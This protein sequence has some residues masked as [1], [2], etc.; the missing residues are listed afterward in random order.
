MIIEGFNKLGKY[1]R[2]CFRKNIIKHSNKNEE[3]IE[4]ISITLIQDGEE[5]NV[6]SPWWF[7]DK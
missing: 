7:F 3:E 1:L 6:F 5:E 4:I 2:E